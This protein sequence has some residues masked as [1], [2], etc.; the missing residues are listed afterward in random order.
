[1]RVREDR[2]RFL[3][4]G[5]MGLMMAGCAVGRGQAV[6]GAPGVL[7]RG[8]EL[9]Q[10]ARL[11][12]GETQTISARR[13]RC[14]QVGVPRSASEA[15]NCPL[16]VTIECPDGSQTVTLHPGGEPTESGLCCQAGHG[17]YTQFRFSCVGEHEEKDCEFWY[18]RGN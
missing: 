5:V 1:M 12:C 10:E 11:N 16:T 14:L 3:L 18:E 9:R 15:F 6:G 4:V 13:N 7:F 8:A 2:L 17:N